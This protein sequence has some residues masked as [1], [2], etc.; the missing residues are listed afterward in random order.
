MSC[1]PGNHLS[2]KS[3]RKWKSVPPSSSAT[4]AETKATPRNVLFRLVAMD[5]LGQEKKKQSN[6]AKMT[7]RKARKKQSNLRQRRRMIKERRRS[8]IHCPRR[9]HPHH[10]KLKRNVFGKPST[11]SNDTSSKSLRNKEIMTMDSLRQSTR[12]WRNCRSLTPTVTLVPWL[13]KDKDE[14]HLK[15]LESLQ[16]RLSSLKKYAPKARAVWKGGQRVVWIKVCVSHKSKWEDLKDDTTACWQ[17]NKFGMYPC[18]LLP[19]H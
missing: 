14:P 17:K 3:M 1:S 18:A 8:L 13:D 2:Q 16:C 4:K 10:V 5:R 9:T 11:R 6:A 19:W 7:R 15:N 12:C